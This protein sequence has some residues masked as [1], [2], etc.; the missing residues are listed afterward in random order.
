MILLDLIFYQL[1]AKGK[2][3]SLCEYIIEVQI[4]S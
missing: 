2:I 4:L 1:E 3:Y